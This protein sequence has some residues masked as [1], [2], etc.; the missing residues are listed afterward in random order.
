MSKKGIVYISVMKNNLVTS[1]FINEVD[2]LSTY[3]SDNDSIITDLNDFYVQ[4][5]RRSVAKMTDLPLHDFRERLLDYTTRA[6]RN[7]ILVDIDNKQVYTG[8]TDKR[9]FVSSSSGLD[10]GKAVEALL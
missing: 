8:A 2:E 5:R 4:I 3:L 10:I 6:H 9:H 1:L 7:I